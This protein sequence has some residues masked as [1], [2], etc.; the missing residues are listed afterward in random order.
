MEDKEIT[1]KQ[2]IRD[3]ITEGDCRSEHAGNLKDFIAFLKDKYKEA[4]N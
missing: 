3:I 4:W 1:N 2:I